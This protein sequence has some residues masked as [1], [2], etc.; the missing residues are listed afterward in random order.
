MDGSLS[1]RIL[2]QSGRDYI[3]HDALIDLGRINA[4]ALDGLTDSNGAELRR[5]QIGEAALKFSDG[6][7]AAGDDDYI[8]KRGHESS[9]REDFRVLIIDATHRRCVAP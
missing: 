3:P 6:R 1:R 7:A 9:S 4:G 5:T 8:V 2:T